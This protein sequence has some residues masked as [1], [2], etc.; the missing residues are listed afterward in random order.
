MAADR[1]GV[2]FHIWCD[3]YDDDD[4]EDDDDDDDD[5]R[6]HQHSGA[7]DNNNDDDGDDVDRWHHTLSLPQRSCHT[8]HTHSQVREM[9]QPWSYFMRRRSWAHPARGWVAG[10]TMRLRDGRTTH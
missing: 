8:G 4:D 1:L 3:D 2:Q 10:L 6:H 7:D 5:W 9:D